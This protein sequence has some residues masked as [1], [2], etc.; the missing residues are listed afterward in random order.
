M[1]NTQ[2]ITHSSHSTSIHSHTCE[3]S[4]HQHHKLGQ[5]LTDSSLMMDMFLTV[6]ATYDKGDYQWDMQ[7]N[8]SLVPQLK[9]CAA[10]FWLCTYYDTLIRSCILIIRHHLHDQTTEQRVRAGKVKQQRAHHKT[11]DCS[12]DRVFIQQI[13]YCFMWLPFHGCMYGVWGQDS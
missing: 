6:G 3:D 2:C 5:K 1:L 11:R 4:H 7:R 9:L 10:I 12:S 13:P 8:D